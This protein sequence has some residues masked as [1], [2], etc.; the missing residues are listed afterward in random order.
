ML[1][2]QDSD[3]KER[4]QDVP[5]T[6]DFDQI[7]K[8]VKNS[9][10]VT[11]YAVSIGRALRE[12]LDARGY[13]GSIQNLDFLQADNQMNTF[14]RMTGGQAFFPRFEGELPEIFHS[15]GNSIRNEYSLGYRPTNT[16]M[17]GSYRKLKVELVAPDGGPL[18]VK[19]QHGKDVKINL[20]AREGYTAKHVVE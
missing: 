7:L 5:V 2:K 15:I 16:K 20:V 3:K 18:K 4:Q 8:K 12:M 19:D 6:R 9:K 14:A 11:I 1:E 13:V 10:D 17:D